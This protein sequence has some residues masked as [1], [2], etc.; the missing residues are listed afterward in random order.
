VSHYFFLITY[1][2]LFTLSLSSILNFLINNLV[3]LLDLENKSR[4][5][6]DLKS[7]K[8]QFF[9]NFLKYYLGLCSQLDGCSR[10]IWK[11]LFFYLGNIVCKLF[12]SFLTIFTTWF[13]FCYIDILSSLQS[14]FNLH[15]PAFFLRVYFFQ[16]WL[17]SWV[18]T[19]FI[20]LMLL[21]ENLVSLS[22]S[23]K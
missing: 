2:S 11:T 16:A 12:L 22:I 17:Y 19:S 1:F 23:L 14:D 18:R 6:D 5:I 15:F 3:E 13:F 9:E 21:L 8:T 4:S 10:L 7:L 20:F